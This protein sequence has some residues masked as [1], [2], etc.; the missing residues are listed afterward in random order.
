[1]YLYG[2]GDKLF[3]LVKMGRRC[4][5]YP[6][7]LHFD[8]LPCMSCCRHLSDEEVRQVVSAMGYTGGG[9]TGQGHWFTCPNGHAYVITECGGAM[10]TS[11]CPE[12]GAVIGGQNHALHASNRP[13]EALLAR[14]GIRG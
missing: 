8:L 10:Q 13:A 1:M 2:P 14:A 11:V 4:Q 6:P 5:T 7:I 9:Y 3:V 12:C